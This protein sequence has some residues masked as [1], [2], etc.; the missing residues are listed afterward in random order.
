MVGG[1][2]QCALCCTRVTLSSE[3]RHPFHIG[4]KGPLY[5]PEGLGAHLDMKC[6]F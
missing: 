5:W 1:G 4:Q 6:P 2:G 3:S